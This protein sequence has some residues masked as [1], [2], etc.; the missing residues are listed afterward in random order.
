MRRNFLVAAF[1]ALVLV[2]LLSFPA[3]AAS[4]CAGGRCAVGQAATATASATAR[5]TKRIVTAPVR[6]ARRITG[7]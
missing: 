5:T 6:V 7:R 3:S 1:A 4:P 2:V